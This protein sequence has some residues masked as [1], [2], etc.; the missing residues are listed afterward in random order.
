MRANAAMVAGSVLAAG[1]KATFEADG[2]YLAVINDKFVALQASEA[3]AEAIFT[4]EI[5]EP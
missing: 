1:D 4:M 5:K 2:K 3:P